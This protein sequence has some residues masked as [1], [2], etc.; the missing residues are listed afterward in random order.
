MIIFGYVHFGV[1]SQILPLYLKGRF[2]AIDAFRHKG[3]ILRRHSRSVPN[4]NILR[5]EFQRIFACVQSM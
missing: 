4:R 1:K 2:Y 3:K 5:K